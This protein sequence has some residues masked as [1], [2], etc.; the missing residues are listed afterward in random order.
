MASAAP[1]CPSSPLPLQLPPAYP[2]IELHCAQ[3]AT[4]SGMLDA[5]HLVQHVTPNPPPPKHPCAAD[6]LRTSSSGMPPTR[7]SAFSSSPS[8][9]GHPGCR[10][11]PCGGGEGGSFP[12]GYHPG[13]RW[14]TC[15]V[16]RGVSS[17]LPLE[18]P[19]VCM[20][21]QSLARGRGTRLEP[22]RTEGYQ[23]GGYGCSARIM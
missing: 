5:P 19:S 8:M 9:V 15:V 21:E 2:P 6:A 13:C 22:G 20:H 23:R 12:G 1:P 11:K 4:G 16:G 17:L 10:W 7:Y 14:Q 18:A 3:L